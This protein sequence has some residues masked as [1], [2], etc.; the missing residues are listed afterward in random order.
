MRGGGGGGRSNAPH[1]L[2]ELFMSSL[3][4]R[5]ILFLPSSIEVLCPLL[6]LQEVLRPPAT[7]QLLVVML[8]P[9]LPLLVMLMSMLTSVGFLHTVCH[10]L[11]II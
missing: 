4:L 7:L 2:Q 8:M 10:L 6:S 3:S 5:E 11:H 9:A 1:P